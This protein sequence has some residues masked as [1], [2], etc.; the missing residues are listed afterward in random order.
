MRE[1][2]GAKGPGVVPP[3]STRSPTSGNRRDFLRFT[4]LSGL[5]VL[6][7]AALAGCGNGEGGL[8]GRG[9]DIITFDFQSETDV[10]RF[11]SALE[12]LE[13]QIY[14]RVVENIGSSGLSAA[15][16]ALVAEFQQNELSHR[17]W[18]RGVLGSN[19]VETTPVFSRVD[20]GSRDGVL[21]TLQTFCDN[22]VSAY[23]GSGRYLSTL[24]LAIAGKLVSV[25]A[26]QAA[27]L[28][29]LR[30]P[31]NGAQGFAGDD[32]VDANGLDVVN[33][34]TIADI[35]LTDPNNAIEVA[36]PYLVQRLQVVNVAAA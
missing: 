35:S 25:E 11:A 23:N 29:D 36:R 30:F 28:R 33:G 31:N 19:Y 15:E 3:G 5:V 12:D 6:L 13:G 16:Q 4:G 24:N 32:V 7:P 10:L 1:K 17:A 26:R 22:G 2:H 9:G 18:F 34:A 14:D 20:F 21:A 27:A 8:T